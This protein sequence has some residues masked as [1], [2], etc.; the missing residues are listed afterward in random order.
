MDCDKKTNV[1]LMVEQEGKVFHFLFFF[2]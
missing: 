2:E 1:D